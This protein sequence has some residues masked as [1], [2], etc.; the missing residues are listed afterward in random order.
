MKKIILQTDN[1]TN[2][3]FIDLIKFILSILVV[4]IHVHPFGDNSTMSGYNF[5][6]TDC[7]GRI[8]V[9]FY[10]VCSSYFVFK[11]I[12]VKEFDKNIPM[13][14]AWRFFRLYI[15]WTIIYIPWIVVSMLEYY[16]SVAHGLI[17]AV[18]NFL[19]VGSYG[20]LWYLNALAIAILLVTFFL[21]K[22]ISVRKTIICA[23]IIYLV[24]LLGNSYMGL[25]K[26][27]SSYEVIWNSLRVIKKVIWT[28]R[29]GLFFGF[30]FVAMGL[31][32]ANT[33][34]LLKV[35]YSFVG[36]VISLTGLFYEVC[37]VTM[38]NWRIDDDMYIS[39]IPV[40][41]FLFN[42]ALQVELKNHKRWK[43]LR[44]ISSLI[45]YT[46]TW[47][48]DAIAMLFVVW[49]VD[50]TKSSLHF[51]L[52]LI[53]SILVANIIIRISENEKFIWLKKL[54]I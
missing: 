25:L 27:L 2:Y 19:I 10:F 37:Y 43:W 50:I 22:K 13:K 3:N 26:P 49:N 11:K 41:F 20:Q 23:T 38:Q 28:T 6:I 9:P 4:A 29:N 21:L 14:A 48:R 32:F 35:K 46:H 33:K 17:G 7:L 39:L 40:T 42:I 44:L 16:N 52:T 47:I 51:V 54:Y 12:D 34:W 36:F 45:F 1:E 53:V 15:L 18:R 31:W 8:A 30:L 24:G 5:W